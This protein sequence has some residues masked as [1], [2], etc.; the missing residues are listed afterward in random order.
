VEAAGEM[1]EEPPPRH[2]LRGMRQL[3]RHGPG[4][5]TRQEIEGDQQQ[6]QVR[7]RGE[8]GRRAEASVL[9]IGPLHQE[10][11]SPDRV[12]GAHLRIG[13]GLELDGEGIHHPPSGFLDFASPIRI[14]VGQGR[15]NL[16]KARHAVSRL[17]GI[18]GAAKEGTAVGQAE[19]RQRPAATSLVEP[20][21]RIHVD[22]VHVG[23]FLAVH[24]DADEVAVHERRGGFILE[25][26]TLHDVTPMAGA[27]ADGDQQR[28]VELFGPLESFRS[29]GIPVHRVLAV[30]E[31]VGARFRRQTVAG[32]AGRRL[33]GRGRVHGRMSSCGG[34]RGSLASP[35]LVGLG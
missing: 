6:F 34:G 17:V 23:P 30:L 19:G 20:D 24:L 28:A 2:L 31:Q 10:P 8:F 26:F 11:A 5:V 4:L 3:Q 14:G 27:V 22:L 33:R 7:R 25:G 21:H 13:G 18:V 32:A 35:A 16:A 12:P 9:G 15:E 1:V 29:P